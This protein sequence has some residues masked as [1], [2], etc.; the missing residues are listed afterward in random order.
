VGKEEGHPIDYCRE[1]GR[2]K[3]RRIGDEEDTR[4]RGARMGG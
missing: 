3:E 4:A 1:K 2:E